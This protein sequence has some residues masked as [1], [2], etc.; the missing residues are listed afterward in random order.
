MAMS[1]PSV[2]HISQPMDG[3]VAVYVAAVAADQA[4][5]GWDVA[6]ACPAE[7]PLRE[8]LAEAGVRW[9]EWSARRSPG[10]ADLGPARRLSRLVGRFGPQVVHLHS[11]KAGLLGRA[12]IRGR[13]PTV[14]QPHGWSW[15]ACQG[16]MAQT[17]LAWE[18]WATRWSDLLV[19][20][21]EGEAEAARA[22]GLNGSITVVRNGVDLHGFPPATEH[23]RQE[24][25]RRYRLPEEKPLAVCIG[26]VTRQKGQDLL[27]AAWEQVRRGCPEARL[28]I[29]GDGDLLAGL[30]AVAGPGVIFAGQVEDTRPWYA[31]ADVVVL[32]SRWEGL[33]LTALEA[34]ATGR[35]L[36]A[37]DIPGLAEV[38]NA[39]V[40]A[41][42]P[43]ERVEPLAQAL[44]RR[45]VDL[46][47]AQSEGRAAAVHAR[48]FELGPA[49]DLVAA[50][51]LVLAGM[52]GAERAS[53]RGATFGRGLGSSR[54]GSPEGTAGTSTDGAAGVTPDGAAGV[55]ADG[56]DG[57]VMGVPAGEDAG[58]GTAAG[59][60]GVGKGSGIIGSGA[61]GRAKWW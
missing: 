5:R 43:A 44:L 15:L 4:R 49:L 61:G 12:V 55:T 25:R 3:G 38:V 60:A 57:T 8:R 6:V 21:G 26:R 47:L 42:V 52:S 10:P 13:L 34:L 19:C 45:M 37:S 14:F 31:A 59:T 28:A 29:V 17:A 27:V 48:E 51:T 53:G 41:V 30:R 1:R 24:A 54:V 23:T 18:R 56:A 9:L 58:Q 39:E 50:H 7:G 20:V 22:L 46:S 35:S 36:V 16:L 2:L 32:P 40:G 33:P 11:A